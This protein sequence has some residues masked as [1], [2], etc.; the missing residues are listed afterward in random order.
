MNRLLLG[1]FFI[2]C[3][4]TVHQEASA[5]SNDFGVGG[6]LDI[7]TAR[8]P[9]EGEFTAS[10]SR[11]DIADIY[12]IGY[13]PF[14]RLEMAFRYTIIDPREQ[15]DVGFDNRDRSFEIKFKILEE[16]RYLPQVSVGT[17]DLLGTG[18]WGG[19]YLVASKKFS[20]TFDVSAGLGWGQLSERA[21]ASNPLTKISSAFAYRNTEFGL[22]GKVSYKSFFRG[23]NIGLFGGARYHIPSLN[24]D[25]LAAYTSDS[26]NVF[27]R[28]GYFTDVVAP[29]SYGIEWEAIPDVRLSVSWQQGSQLAFHLSFA[30][31]TA[32]IAPRKSPNS[33][34]A[35]S[36]SYAR[37]SKLDAK[38]GWW[39]RIVSDAESSGV[40][41]KSGR[42]TVDGK[43]VLQY[44]NMT[45]Q[46]E[47]DAVRRVLTL[48]DL[49]AP[50]QVKDVTLTGD[51]LGMSSHSI[52]YQRADA[53]KPELY[54]SLDTIE[55][56]SPEAMA[57][58]NFR[59][60]YRYPNGKTSVG[61]NARAYIF[62]PDDPLL[63][64]IAL[65]LRGD[66]DF[67]GGWTATGAWNQSLKSQFQRIGRDS[68]SA[69]EAVR[70]RAPDYLKQGASGI[71]DLVLI[72]RGKVA[73]DIYYQLYGGILEEMFSGAG[74]E[75]LWR[76]FASRLAVGANINSVQQ[77]EY[78]KMFGLRDY[79]TITGHASI[80]WAT[81]FYGFDAAVHM[82]RYLA[83]DV[84]ATFEVQKRFANGWSVGV[85]A[86]KTNV[87]AAD[88][89]EG[90]FD[91][92]LIFK[93][94]FDLYSP[95][96]VKG[97][98]RTIIRSINRDGGRMLDE[99]PNSLW[100]KLRET[101]SDR[102]HD[103]QDRMFPE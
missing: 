7:P 45:Y 78:K 51:A 17:R 41:I 87:S 34:G 46:V 39:P 64:Q 103:N 70:T 76:P 20:N 33:F 29:L 24:L 23:P 10:Y 80:Y 5:Q 19:E 43:L 18:Q 47:A 36:T 9:K 44:S 73:R 8:M 81:P 102:L 58:P 14:P 52:H 55:I 68:G 89:G 21:I 86:T 98:Y 25:L 50:A 91:K 54:R 82:G 63:Y 49:Y 61:I 67:G 42:E 1:L 69:L 4:N 101:H 74:G 11:K 12:A 32:Q 40:L 79:K 100:E 28:Q 65:K 53:Q 96:N 15:F 22:G 16:T 35:G 30:L 31:D 59:T 2:G 48:T 75:I 66:A 27:K 99:W 95:K 13:Q 60:I 94:P 57:P 84:G 3:L 85:F 88:F 38:E 71:D 77:R 93:I 92:G 72:K 97:S 37:V 26:Y 56:T 90:S 62:D 6:I 83:R